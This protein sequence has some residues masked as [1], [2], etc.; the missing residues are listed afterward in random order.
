[1]PVPARPKKATP[2]RKSK[3][4]VATRPPEVVDAEVV[5]D[6]APKARSPLEHQDAGEAREGVVE[7]DVEPQ[8]EELEDV[9]DSEELSAADARIARRDPL[10]AYMAEVTKHPLL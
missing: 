2:N 7:P 1:M 10:S 5:E 4:E 3:K 8:E 9:D 6:A